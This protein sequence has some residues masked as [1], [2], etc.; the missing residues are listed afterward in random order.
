MKKSR[1]LS[2]E[3]MIKYTPQEEW[4]EGKGKLIW[5]AFFF[6]EIGA[7]IYFVSLFLNFRPGWLLGWLVALVLG[8]LIHLAYLGKPMRIWRIL[9]RPASSEISRGM[10][11]TLLF[12]LVGFFQVLPIA[13]PGLWWTGEGALLKTMTG[14]ICILMVTHGFLTM[15]VVKALPMWNSSMMIPLS[16]ASG[17]WVGSHTV[18]MML[19]LGEQELAGAELWVRWSLL[20]YMGVLSIFLWGA[21]HASETVRE[22]IR[23]LL[24]GDSSLPFYIGVVG[25]GLLIP[26]IITLLIWGTGLER[27]DGST[28]FVRFISVLIGDLM[29]RHS[30]MKR[31]FYSPLI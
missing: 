18:Q 17:I 1:A 14:I 30:I 2:H 20:C 26:L 4:I 31:A 3:W 24:K 12:A 27:L 23:H 19:Y 15:S 5:L 13:V 9:F 21:A 22:S 11:V 7:S 6:S 25:I 10:W 28:L 16:L 8:G 29:M